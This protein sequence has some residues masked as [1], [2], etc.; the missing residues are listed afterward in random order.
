M[1]ETNELH[2]IWNLLSVRYYFNETQ[3][4]DISEFFKQS[5]AAGETQLLD[6]DTSDSQMLLLEAQLQVVCILNNQLP[7][8]ATEW[9]L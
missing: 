8:I 2:K 7:L 5:I 4:K 3:L 1:A 6:R 9:W